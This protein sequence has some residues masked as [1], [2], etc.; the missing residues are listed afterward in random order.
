M[1]C[2]V[3]SP[4]I[5][6]PTHHHPTHHPPPHTPPPPPIVRRQAIT[7]INADLLSIG[8]LGII[9]PSKP[10]KV[11]ASCTELNLSSFMEICRRC[12]ALPTN[13]P[14]GLILIGLDVR[15]VL[16]LLDEQPALYVFM[17]PRVHCRMKIAFS[18]EKICTSDVWYFITI[19]YRW[20]DTILQWC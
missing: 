11:N 13:K 15:N 4:T 5:P 8:L 14:R 19:I 6:H 1:Y 20:S 3:N 16:C 12:L 17:H 7:W 2:T 9:H 10:L 18:L